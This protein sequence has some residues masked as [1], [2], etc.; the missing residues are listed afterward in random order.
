MLSAPRAIDRQAI[1]WL[2]AF[3]LLALLF[4]KRRTVFLKAKLR[5]ITVSEGLF[6]NIY[7]KKLTCIV[8]QVLLLKLQRKTKHWK[9][10]EN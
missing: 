8:D 7:A 5:G 10:P 9:Y 2:I 4:R 3:S 1:L 6:Y